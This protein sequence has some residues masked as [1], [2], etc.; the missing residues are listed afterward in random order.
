[1]IYFTG[2]Y[3]DINYDRPLNGSKSDKNIYTI[4]GKLII[5][6]AIKLND[7]GFF[8]EYGGSV[9]GFNWCNT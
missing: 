3:I 2:G 4:N 6:I 8:L 9:K 5:D 1:M 7:S